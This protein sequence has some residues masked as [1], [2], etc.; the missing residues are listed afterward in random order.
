MKKA[1]IQRIGGLLLSS[2]ILF[3]SLSGSVSAATTGV[4]SVSAKSAI[5]IEASTGRVLF[6]K[7]EREKLPMART[8]KIMSARLTLESGNLDKPFEVDGGAIMVEGSSMGLQKGDI[9]TRR[10][11]AYGMLLPSGNDAAG[12]AAVSVAGSQSEFVAMMNKRAQMLGLD[13]THF[14]TPSGLDG[15]EHYSTAWDMAMLART[16]LQN[17]DFL[18]ICS[19][20]TAKV[21]FGNPPYTRYMTNH[22]R[23]VKEYKGCIGVKTGFTKKAGRCLVSA[24]EREG[25][26]LIAVTLNA[27][28]DWSDH[29]KMF[30]YGFSVV[31]TSPLQVDVSDIRLKV[32][33]GKTSE[34]KVIPAGYPT[35]CLSEEEQ[36]KLTTKVLAPQFCY[37]PVE[38][39]SLVGEIQYWYEDFMIASVSL[40]AQDSVEQNIT[41][42]QYTFW[43]KVAMF[44]KNI[45][46]NL[47][48]FLQKIW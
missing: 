39:G 28:N 36:K 38:S 13:S 24:A 37:A 44:F 42:V 7:N 10:T 29:K 8:T 31:K 41:P 48:G 2:A 9:V 17:P 26:R 21:E 40:L 25:V 12:A 35:V 4:P 23:L 6:S 45:Y 15:K 32:V 22:N 16:A 34:I 27:P 43:E 1:C 46:Y 20:S 5:L 33:G 30:D 19:K 11:L 18:E 3:F 47:L 14:E